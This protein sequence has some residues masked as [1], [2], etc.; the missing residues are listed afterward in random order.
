MCYVEIEYMEALPTNLHMFSFEEWKDWRREIG[1]C[2]AVTDESWRQ[3][4]VKVI[5]RFIPKQL[6]ESVFGDVGFTSKFACS[7]VPCLSAMVTRSVC[8]FE[9]ASLPNSRF[10][11]LFRYNEYFKC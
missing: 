1:N 7:L 6:E 9:G 3:R 4:G 2:C 8:K 10:F 5:Q 11:K